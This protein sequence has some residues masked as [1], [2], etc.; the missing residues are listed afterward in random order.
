[1]E[2]K[3]IKNPS[4]VKNICIERAVVSML[5]KSIWAK[6]LTCSSDFNR[7]GS[8]SINHSNITYGG[9]DS[10]ICCMVDTNLDWSARC[11]HLSQSKSVST[12]QQSL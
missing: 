12:I 7:V 5:C 3:H 6:N 11:G 2:K 8:L 10:Y 1:M 9:Y 4:K